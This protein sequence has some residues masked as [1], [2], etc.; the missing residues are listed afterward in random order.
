MKSYSEF[1]DYLTEACDC[2]DGYKRKPGT[3][4]C[5]KGSCIKEEDIE[6]ASAEPVIGD[7]KQTILCIFVDQVDRCISDAVVAN[8][9]GIARG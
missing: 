1:M 8:S 7:I 9:Q 3:K 2:W 5:D 6:E 4:P